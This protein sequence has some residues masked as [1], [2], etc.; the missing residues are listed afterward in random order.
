MN[1]ILIGALILALA[2]L[3]MIA[4]S[5]RV[6]VSTND[7]HIVQSAKRTVSY[8]KDQPAGNTYY[9][10]PAW[11]PGIGVR[12]I[13]LPVSV[14]DIKLE[15]Y[16]AYDKG[17]VP[18]LIDIMAFFRVHDSNMAA[19]RVSTVGELNRQLQGI[20]Q[21]VCRTILANSEIEEILEGRSRFGE[22]FTKEVDGNLVQWGVQSVKQIE[23]MDIRDGQGSNVIA[24]IMAKKKS[25]IEKESRVAV[26]ENM[27]AAQVAEIDANQA[28]LVRQQEAQ[29]FVGR[30]TA[31]KEKNVGLANQAAQQAIKEQ[32]RETADRDMA[33][34]RVKTVRQAEI[35]RDSQIVAAEQQRQVAVIGAE[36]HKQQ[37]VLVAEGDL[38]SA[39]LNAQ[40]VEVKGQADGAAQTAVLM[41]PV[42]SQINLAK[43]IGQNPGYQSYLV[44]VRTIEKDEAVGIA[45]AAALKA[46]DI[47]V[48]ANSGEVMPG[49]KS[50]MELL[51]PKGGTQ[52]GAMVEAFKQTPAGAA[53]LG[54]LNGGNKQD[55]P[56][57]LATSGR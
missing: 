29:E 28:V 26:A 16:A 40:G 46:A 57:T 30:R 20:L 13:A 8:G 18:F 3:L 5:F 44:N 51:T 12:V 49:V 52:L 41:A 10:W 55:G 34:V 47:K 23:L 43:E 24:N 33:I 27:R 53:L 21:G 39:K 35:Q 45:T 38:A 6:V 31:D 7:V 22:L 4:A 32:E 11:I 56:P 9:R 1:L 37:T 48:I 15:G 36:A 50:V 2:L 42:T 17:R 14:F 19:Q 25:T 54:H